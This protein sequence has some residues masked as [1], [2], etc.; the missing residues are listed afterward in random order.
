MVNLFNQ[1][2]WFSY[3]KKFSSYAEGYNNLKISIGFCITWEKCLFR[4]THSHVSLCYFKEILEVLTTSF[5]QIRHPICVTNT[6]SFS[7]FSFW[8]KEKSSKM[9]NDASFQE[10]LKDIEAPNYLIGPSVVNVAW[11]INM[12]WFGFTP[13]LAESAYSTLHDLGAQ[14]VPVPLDRI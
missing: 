2:Q 6:S 3:L 14:S 1:N 13:P 9:G 8:K 7:L 10:K 5:V 12:V 4:A 11:Y